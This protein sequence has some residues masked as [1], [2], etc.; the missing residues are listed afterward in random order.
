MQRVGDAIGVDRA[1]G[2]DE[3]LSEHLPAIDPLPAF[4]G[5][6][7]AKQVALERFEIQ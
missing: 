1:D 2:S 4:L 7:T 3:G 5:A 6:A